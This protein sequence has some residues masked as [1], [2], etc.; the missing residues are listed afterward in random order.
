MWR[1]GE[2]DVDLP[3]RGD[4]GLNQCWRLVHKSGKDSP[5]EIVSAL[6]S[7]YCLDVSEG[8]WDD[9]AG[10]ILWERHG[11]KNQEWYT[12]DNGDGTFTIV[13]NGLGPKL[14]LDC[15]GGGA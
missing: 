10:L 5:Y 14:V 7:R 13:N 12:L 9:G 15:V 3:L 8:S 1:R 6:D 4:D 11:G 2:R